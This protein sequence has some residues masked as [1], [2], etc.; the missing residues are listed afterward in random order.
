MPVSSIDAVTLNARL[1]SGEQPLLLDVREPW[2]FGIA[3]LAGSRNLP[4][5]HIPATVGAWPHGSP[6]EEIVIIC[7]HGVRSLQ[8]AHFLES[9][10]FKNLV[11]LEGGIHAWSQQVD[12]TM[13]TY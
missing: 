10:G 3:A 7:H 6:E 2:E 12:P 13:P 8:V 9:A 4:M 11:N 5:G 1:G